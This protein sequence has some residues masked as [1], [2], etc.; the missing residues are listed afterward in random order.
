MHLSQLNISGDIYHI[1]MDHQLPSH[2]LSIPHQHSLSDTIL[3]QHDNVNKPSSLSVQA[4]AG[5]H[6]TSDWPVQETAYSDVRSMSVDPGSLDD[7]LSS[8]GSG[9]GAKEGEF[10]G[11]VDELV[12]VSGNGAARLTGVTKAHKGTMVRKMLCKCK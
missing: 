5:N 3:S 10:S 9:E 12:V 2:F 8:P 6:Q 4:V 11:G 1:R 7:P